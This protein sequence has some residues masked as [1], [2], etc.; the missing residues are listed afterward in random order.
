MRRKSRLFPDSGLIGIPRFP[1]IPAESDWGQNPEYF[2]DTAQSGS[3]ESRLFSRPNRG[4]AGRDSGISGS[5]WAGAR[6]HSMNTVVGPLSTSRGPRLGIVRRVRLACGDL[7]RSRSYQWPRRQ[8]GSLAECCKK[9]QAAP[10]AT[11]RR[12]VRTSWPTQWHGYL[13]RGG[14]T[15]SEHARKSA[16]TFCSGLPLRLARGELPV[17]GAGGARLRAWPGGAGVWTSAGI[18]GMG[19]PLQAIL[20][21]GRP[22]SGHGTAQHVGPVLPK[23]PP[24]LYS[25]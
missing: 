5:G 13:A 14:S 4:G 1:E 21:M 19:G 6:V 18:L 7:R 11:R 8:L 17:G 10:G 3:G 25:T 20:G 22:T 15:H 9:P 24:I 2:P 12:A 23:G 16:A